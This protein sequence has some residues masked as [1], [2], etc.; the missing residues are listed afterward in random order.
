MATQPD[1]GGNLMRVWP[2]PIP[3]WYW[4]WAEWWLGRGA[5]KQHKRDLEWRPGN[6]PA[7]IPYW[8]WARLAAQMGNPIPPKPKPK[9]VPKPPPTVDKQLAKA[10][11]MLAY[12]RG[13]TGHYLY[14]GGHGQKA[15]DL[16]RQM[17]LD[18][19]SSTSLLLSEFGLLDSEWVQVSGW[20]ES[21][22]LYGTGK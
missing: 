2:V 6:V 8:A 22:G 3:D 10:R 17:N 13:F 7:R 18:C 12:A 19:S 21:W 1:E 14:G 15:E 20:F 5:Y 9:P 4:R 16:N 11:D